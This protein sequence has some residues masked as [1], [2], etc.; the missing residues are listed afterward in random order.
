MYP[1][2]STCLLYRELEYEVE[3]EVR[4]FELSEDWNVNET[5]Y[6]SRRAKK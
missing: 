6:E 3:E 2:P 5:R 4:S 1:F